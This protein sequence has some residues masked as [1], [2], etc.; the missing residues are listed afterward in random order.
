MGL[1]CREKKGG[2]GGRERIIL[3]RIRKNKYA[4]YW[5]T[6]RAWHDAICFKLKCISTK[7]G[8]ACQNVVHGYIPKKMVYNF[9]LHCTNFAF[10]LSLQF[11]ILI[12]TRF[13]DIKDLQ[14][15][16]WGLVYMLL[17]FKCFV[18]ELV[19]PLLVQFSSW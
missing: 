4:T 8:Q 15:K 13:I 14:W 10:L 18:S 2:G 3:T 7:R 19:Y 11:Y 6:A 1:G 17:Q 9:Y 16:F 5:L 12:D